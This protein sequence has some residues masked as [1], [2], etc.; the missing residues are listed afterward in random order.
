MS[1]IDISSIA[2]NIA[3]QIANYVQYAEHTLNQL[4]QIE[5][6]VTQI[7]NQVTQFPHDKLKIAA[8][9]WQSG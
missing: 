2:H 6:G 5:Q 4:T 8:E 9:R 1:V 7:T 3:A